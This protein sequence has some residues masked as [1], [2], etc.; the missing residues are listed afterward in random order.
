MLVPI[1]EL[2]KLVHVPWSPEELGD[3][4]TN[5]GLEMRGITSFGRRDNVVIG[6]IQNIR[7][8][9]NADRLKIVEVDIGKKSLSLVCGAPNVEE[10][11]CVAVALEGAE[12]SG[13]MKVKK[14]RIRGVDS[15]GMICSEREL[16]L[17]EDHS[18]IMILPDQL[19]PGEDFS[20][21]LGIEDTV[22]DLEIPSNRGDCLS[23]VGIAREIAAL[24]REKFNFPSIQIQDNQVSREENLPEIRINTPNCSYY[25]ARVIK[26]VKVDVSPLWLRNKIFI[27]GA[28]P[29]NNVV[30]VTNYVMW[31][32][33]QPLHPFDFQRIGGQK[34]IVRQAQEEEALL[35][36]DEKFRQLNKEIMVI[37]DHKNPIALAGIIGGQETEVNS[38]TQDILLEAAYFSPISVGETSRRIGLTTEASSR[39]EKGVD[40]QIV[41]RALERAAILIQQVA[42]GKII[43][44]A[45]KA[46][47][48][49]DER[50]RIVFHPSRVNRITGS[51]ISFSTMEEILENLEFQV[52]KNRGKW[53]IK[54]PGF[55][56]DIRREIDLVEEVCRLYGYN[57]VGTTLPSLGKQE[58]RESKEEIVKNALRNLLRGCGFYEVVTNSLIGEK[59]FSMSRTSQKKA[60]NV[61]NPLS[62]EQKTLRTRLFPQLLDVASFNYNQEAKNIRFVEIGRVFTRE[63]NDFR[64]YSSLGG[65][66]IENNFDFLT[67]KGIVESIFDET[68]I[69]QIEFAGQHFPYCAP[70]ESAIIRKDHLT[71]GYLG[72]I[73][74]GVCENFKLPEQTYF[75]ELCF[76]L[77]LSLYKE[78]KHY[79]PLPRFPSVK[80]DM[81]ILIKESIS[82]RDVERLVLEKGRFVEDVEFFDIYRGEN[83]PPGHK[84]LSFSITFRHSRKTLTDEEVNK[85]QDRILE[86]LKVRLGASLRTT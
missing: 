32:M 57:K 27:M 61:R 2:R 35:T 72:R 16:A 17:G 85:I 39:F 52:E 71:L 84:S 38:T 10:G 24:T 19:T 29:V 53:E 30:D 83:I 59:L 49:P 47:K 18:G 31:Q 25:A 48:A 41:R 80:R 22:L 20:R 7:E 79:H 15:P 73:H 51:R 23:F 34:I 69:G 63:K 12:L 37:A 26:G 4:L 36:L 76:D 86:S 1:S 50:K 28:K 43:E 75:F 81:S 54:V 42:G 3:K 68:R 40:P 62:L 14:T 8:H 64:E 70:G 65:V 58:E 77:L 21:A 13:G 66:V 11:R 55:R 5:L 67:L 60:V 9:P 45:V 78:D 56:H 74:P 46:G 33:G 44:P 82:T 6:K